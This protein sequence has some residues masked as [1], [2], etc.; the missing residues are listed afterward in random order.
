MN[1]IIQP[2]FKNEILYQKGKIS[3]K[4]QK[5]NVT[6]GAS[7]GIYELR[8]NPFKKNQIKSLKTYIIDNEYYQKLKALIASISTEKEFEASRK[9][10]PIISEKIEEIK[11]VINLAVGKELPWNNSNNKTFL[12]YGDDSLYFGDCMKGRFKGIHA[13]IIS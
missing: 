12:N 2:K 6:F 4:S 1:L 10:N 13:E 11:R 8:N 7:I 9:N 5:N 3:D